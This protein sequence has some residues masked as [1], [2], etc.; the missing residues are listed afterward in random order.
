[1]SEQNKIKKV[2]LRE[3]LL[4][5]TGDY[6][7]AIILNQFIYWSERV[8]DADKFIEQENEIAKKNNETE[9]DLFYGWIYKTSA[10]LADEIMLGISSS[11][12]GRYVKEL[13]DYGFL[14]KRNNPKYKWD[15]TLQ[16]RVNLV[17]IAIA[18][19]EKGYPLSDYK[20]D[21]SAL[22]SPNLCIPHPCN[23]DNE[24]I[25]YQ[26]CVSDETIP[27]IT[28]NNTNKNNS[29]NRTSSSSDTDFDSEI[30]QKV[31]E[32]TDDET[33]IEAIQYYLDKYK[34]FTGKNHPNVSKA[35]LNDIIYNIQTVLQDEWEDVVNEDWLERMINRH[36]K[37]DYGQDID[38]NIVHF[39]TEKI[40]E[41][42]A[43][44]VGLITGWRD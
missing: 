34:R 32:L 17:N 43:R 16:Y 42:Q 28:V 31:T 15:R 29:L 14:S 38:Y 4:A 41:Y 12:V 10:E 13:C 11:Q 39:G 19:R 27:Y 23:M 5:I 2:V 9:R 1:M 35:A 22:E 40:L 33:I 6:R 24:P 25:Q 3:D 20:I 7:K 8:S 21:I 36:F 37:T 30:M 44:N 26:N 18:L